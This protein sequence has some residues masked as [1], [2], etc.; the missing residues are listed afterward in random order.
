V[1]RDW[2]IR[3]QL[4]HQEVGRSLPLRLLKTTAQQTA[5][6]R[7]KHN[8]DSTS[9]L[10]VDS[11]KRS[12][13]MR[14]IRVVLPALLLCAGS[15][16][17][18]VRYNYASGT[19]YSKYHTYKWTTCKGAD[20]LD[21][22]ADQEVKSAIDV[23]LAKK[24]LTKTDAEN[25]DLYVC[26]QVSVGQEKQFATF[27]TGWGPGPGWGRGWYGAGAGMGGM[28]GMGGMSTTT[29]STIQI[30]QL[31]FDMYDPASKQLVW[32]GTASKTLDPQAKPDKR[33]KELAKGAEKLFKNYPPPVKNG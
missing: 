15:F 3:K 30:G 9:G 4:R 19:D 17:Q 22:I 13:K 18:D 24:G 2:E 16:A 32:R 12:C 8:E 1:T 14:T 26:Y 28:G 11:E 33:R 6:K 23:E 7:R 29:S 27:D 20:Q 25:A 10:P 5:P 21:Q 31:D